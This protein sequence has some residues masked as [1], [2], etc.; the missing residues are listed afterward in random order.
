MI[1]ELENKRI[2]K[3]LFITSLAFTIFV[4][5]WVV[6]MIAN[7]IPGSIGEQLAE[8]KRD[9]FLY[10]LTFVNASMISITLVPM[11]I[12][13]ALFNDIKKGFSNVWG[14]VLQVPYTIL[15]SIGYTS[16][17]VALPRILSDTG[18]D[19][20]RIWY[21]GNPSGIPYFLV[22][23]G[24]TFFSLSAL[25]IGWGYIKQ[26][27]IR[28]LIGWLL[29]LSGITGII[30]FIG[31]VMNVSIIELGMMISGAVTLPFG[32]ISALYGLRLQKLN[33]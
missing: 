20:A 4:I 13:L 29:W 7:Q 32:I 33:R 1:N 9:P 14:A 18:I 17:Y 25:L 21:F 8:I 6:F 10:K 23:L 5:L 2:G 11:M 19:S 26:K 31:M 24:Y 15:V 27:G 3:W 30:G 28:R 12:I 16:Q 22:F